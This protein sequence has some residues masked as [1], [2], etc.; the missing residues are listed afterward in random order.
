[1]KEVYFFREFQV[2]GDII[3]W[4]NKDLLIPVVED[5][6]VKVEFHFRVALPGGQVDG[7][8]EMAQVPPA[9]GPEDRKVQTLQGVQLIEGGA[10]GFFG[11]HL[12]A[13]EVFVRVVALKLGVADH[14]GV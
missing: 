6:N 11:Q 8:E 1:M 12:L 13:F 14:Q 5:R 2:F 9:E 7:D 10:E 3:N 4:Q